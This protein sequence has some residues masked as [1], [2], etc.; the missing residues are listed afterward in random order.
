DTYTELLAN[1]QTS[2]FIMS[3]ARIDLTLSSI[4]INAISELD[5]TEFIL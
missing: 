3:D 4:D 5:K 2:D 1:N